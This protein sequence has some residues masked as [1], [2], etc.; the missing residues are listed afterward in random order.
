MSEAMLF[1]LTSPLHELRRFPFSESLPV[2]F[3]PV[4]AA[5]GNAGIARHTNRFARGV[6][7]RSTRDPC[8]LVQTY[9]AVRTPLSSGDECEDLI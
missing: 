6:H 4:P 1:D 3:R 2:A 8:M 7:T 5:T 9:T